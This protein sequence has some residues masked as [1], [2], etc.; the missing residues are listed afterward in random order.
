MMRRRRI[1][2]QIQAGFDA[3]ILKKRLKARAPIKRKRA[4]KPR[5]GRVVDENYMAWLATRPALV[6]GPGRITIHHVRRF[7]EPKNDRRTVPLPSSLHSIQ[8]NARTSVE[9]LGR[10]GF[11]A[12]HQV[13][14]EAAIVSYN[15]QYQAL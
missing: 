8:E 2:E 7:G 10:E 15:E 14:F 3:W 12:Y 5:N 6:S 13:D 4:G 9:A 1:K 11:Q